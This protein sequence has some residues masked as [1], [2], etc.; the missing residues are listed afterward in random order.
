MNTSI[1]SKI[2]DLV[3]DGVSSVPEMKRHLSAFIKRELG[4]NPPSEMDT[5][6]Y[7]T[8]KTVANHIRMAQARLRHSVID[9]E[10]VAQ[11]ASSHYTW[12]TSHIYIGQTMFP[13][14]Y[15]MGECVL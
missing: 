15:I 2:V 13:I 9:L 12:N 6:F 1:K 14:A 3:G 4:S 11:M 8:D 10:N 7:P 5:A